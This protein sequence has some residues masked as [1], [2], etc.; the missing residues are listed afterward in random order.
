MNIKNIYRFFIQVPGLL[1]FSFEKMSNL[2]YLK[3]FLVS[4]RRWLS[5][6]GVIDGYS[7]I[8]S[9]FADK[10]G[11]AA[12]HYFHQDLL[13]AQYIYSHGPCRHIDIGSRIDGF[14]AHVA[15]FRQIEVVD[16]RP[17]DS[18]PH[19]NIKFVKA[20]INNLSENFNADSVSCLHVLEHFGLGRYSD[21]IDVNGHLL[22]LERLINLVSSGGHLYL[23]VPISSENRVEFNAH[24]VFSPSYIPSLPIVCKNLELLNFDYVD[25]SGSLHKNKS[26]YDVPKILNFGCGIYSFKK[27]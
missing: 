8:L 19:P 5:Q 20:D 22:G 21:P 27:L 10:A 26:V 9:D 6:S 16:I 4:R 14:V 11:R 12:G 13:V 7:I 17:A 24:R 23:S 15:S 18:S 25:D 2:R 1:G 3:S